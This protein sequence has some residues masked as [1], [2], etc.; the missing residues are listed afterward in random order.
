MTFF[1]EGAK[2]NSS[3]WD[4]Y[5]RLGDL[6]F[7]RADG[8]L[9]LPEILVRQF[10]VHDKRLNGGDYHRPPIEF[11]G[12]ILLFDYCARYEAAGA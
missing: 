6:G 5:S 10:A 7:L 2:R 8:M 3:R 9:F 1:A 4:L 11:V 12:K